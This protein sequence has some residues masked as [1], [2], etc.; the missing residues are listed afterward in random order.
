MNAKTAQE[1]YN[2]TFLINLI[3]KGAELDGKPI[4][5]ELM[6]GTAGDDDESGPS[7]NANKSQSQNSQNQNSANSSKQRLGIKKRGMMKRRFSGG[8]DNNGGRINDRFSRN[9]RDV[10]RFDGN[11]PQSAG[12]FNNMNNR[13]RSN[14]FNRF[15]RN[16]RFRGGR[17]GSFMRGS[18]MNR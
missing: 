11:R 18:R 4:K 9:N 1:E 7:Q 16:S 2:G 10:G 5:I 15:D 13:D 6:V 3:K 8:N 14:S 17:G 12:R